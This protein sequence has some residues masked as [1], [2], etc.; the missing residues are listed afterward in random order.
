MTARPT[1]VTSLVARTI[2]PVLALMLVLGILGVIGVYRTNR[3]VN[4]VLDDVAPGMAVNGEFMQLMTD[5]ETGVRGWVIQGRPAALQPYRAALKRL[6]A[7]SDELRDYQGVRPELE[8]LVAEQRARSE[9]WLATYARPRLA[10]GPGPRGYDA[11]RFAEGRRIFD[12]L[13]AV[14][15][16]IDSVFDDEAEKARDTARLAYRRAIIAMI[17]LTLGAALSAWFLGRRFRIK[18]QGPLD[19]LEATVN[20]LAAGE[21]S[22]RAPVTGP[23]EIAAVATAFNELAAESERAQ[24]VEVQTRDRLLDLDQAKTDFVSN[25]SHELR[26]PL[27]SIKGY[28]EL[29][30]DECGDGEPGT[31]RMWEIVERNVGRLGVLVEDLLTLA[32][33]ESHHTT[34]TEIDLRDVVDDVAADLRIAAANRGITMVV[35]LPPRSV[36]VLADKTQLLRAV[37]NVVSNA[38]KFCR[39]DG[40]VDVVLTTDGE[41]AKLTVRD[42]G[43]GIPA[44]D[45]SQ[46]GGRFFRG[47]NAVR[48]EIGGT[49]LGVRMVQTILNRHGGRVSF[50][51]VENEY[52]LVTMTLPVRHDGGW[53]E[54]GPAQG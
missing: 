23:R 32:N 20:R 30:R 22:A 19:D 46:L 36:R 9:E 16:H 24:R 31:E 15:A 17:V 14:N 33:V 2:T 18:V 7:V 43:I 29:L 51:S 53:D 34:L 49:G 5:A 6:P 13:R 37:L 44:A 28:L 42:T 3:A 1:S 52:T 38:V 40:R 4:R 45:L 54:A 47:S 25:V 48:L 12:E 35:D 26:T 39:D 27:T 11:R 8:D 50:D 21:T 10:S 41:S